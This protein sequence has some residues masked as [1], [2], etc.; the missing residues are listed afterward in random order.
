MLTVTFEVDRH[1]AIL[2]GIA[3]EGTH[4]I[5]LSTADVQ[6]L[7]EGERELLA[8][9]PG[10]RSAA[11]WRPWRGLSA[12]FLVVEPTKE[13]FLEALRKALSDLHDRVQSK[14]EQEAKWTRERHEREARE[15][16]RIGLAVEWLR[17]LSTS[18]L[19]AAYQFTDNW[20][21]AQF[22]LPDLGDPAGDVYAVS[23]A[24][25]AEQIAKVR[26]R[27]VKAVDD[28][29]ALTEQ[30]GAAR[31]EAL[32]GVLRTYGTPEQVA[33]FN[34]GLCPEV[35]AL[36]LQREAL[37]RILDD[38]PRY[39]RIEESE[40]EH[41]EDCGGPDYSTSVQVATAL[42]DAQYKR[43]IVLRARLSHEYTAELREHRVWCS[44]DGCEDSAV[45][46]RIGLLV[47]TT[48]QGL[49]FSREYSLDAE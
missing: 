42:T 22:K 47:E 5:Q 7:T 34:E 9:V 49:Q 48:W 18:E 12:H 23:E 21:K 32:L 20:G 16:V 44:D 27:R 8:C 2:R 17:S 33:R 25:V 10:G 45:V 39:A 4:T 26:A 28:A 43:L 36:D 30:K 41:T 11:Q 31:R 1:A 29:K 35:E 40:V 15:A 38:V 14:A 24:L 37:F 6:T 19:D 46:S 3:A 13:G